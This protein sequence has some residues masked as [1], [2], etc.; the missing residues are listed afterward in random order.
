VTFTDGR[1]SRAGRYALDLAE[2]VLSTF[3]Q[4]FLGALVAGGW[5]DIGAIGDLSI[6]QKA[7][8]AGIVAVLALGKGLVAKVVGR[9]DSASLVAGV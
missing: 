7:A 9:P 8:A 3:V 6:V 4:A 2:R 5:F 1:V